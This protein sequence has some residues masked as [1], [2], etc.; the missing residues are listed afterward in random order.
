MAEIRINANTRSLQQGIS[1]TTREAQ[2][3]TRTLTKTKAPLL[4]ASETN[5]SI[6]ANQ[7][8]GRGLQQSTANLRRMNQAATQSI[9]L[10]KQQIAMQTQMIQQQQKYIA[11]LQQTQKTGG[12]TGG[13]GAPT[14]LGPVTSRL[15]SFRQGIDQRMAPFGEMSR[16]IGSVKGM[17]GMFLAPLAVP[18]GLMAALGSRGTGTAIQRQAALSGLYATTGR[19]TN[20]AGLGAAGMRMGYTQAQTFQMATQQAQAFGGFSRGNTMATMQMARAYNLSP[21]ALMQL[22]QA[23]RITGATG[24][25]TAQDINNALVQ[26][27]RSGR[28]SSA[29]MNEFASTLTG[30]F[31][32]MQDRAVRANLN[33]VTGILSTAG[34]QMGG[35]FARSPMATGRLLGRADMALRGGQGAGQAMMLSALMRR[36]MNY[37]QAQERLQE[38]IFSGNNFATFLRI[39]RQFG[40]GAMGRMVA[41]QAFGISA[42]DLRALQKIDPSAVTAQQAQ[43][44]GGR[45]VRVGFGGR[46]FG[47][48][49]GEIQRR[50]QT[51][52][53]MMAIQR[54]QIATAE[55][56]ADLRIQMDPAFAAGNQLLVATIQKLTGT[57]GVLL[58]KLQSAIDSMGGKFGR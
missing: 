48:T 32:S 7:K 29:M 12:G 8:Y 56:F 6:R 18:V 30:I 16:V 5:K 42:L 22:Q 19:R 50:A 47:G 21:G 9:N 28:F 51:A 40:Q 54:R 58:P 53:G 33:I 11:L 52:S 31:G 20:L 2:K 14:T 57:M 49:R 44:A 24:A 23:T 15:R 55:T 26:G 25:N 13:R 35:Q 4:H 45:G 10:Q 39:S 3:L 41:S 1:V 46:V 17:L 34:R 43:M 37:A 27:L 38:G 36:G